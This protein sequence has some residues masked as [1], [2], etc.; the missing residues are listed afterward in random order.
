M[1]VGGILV[2][3][4]PS[5]AS[6]SPNNSFSCKSP[7]QVDDAIKVEKD[8]AFVQQELPPRQIERLII[9]DRQK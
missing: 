3:Q 1:G 9:V 5:E 2:K 6:Y 8:P 4:I 7:F